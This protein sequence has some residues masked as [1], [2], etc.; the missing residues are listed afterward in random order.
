MIIPVLISIRSTAHR[1]EGAEDEA[2]TILTSGT[3]T[4]LSEQSAMIRYEET[5]DE[6]MPP[7]T[8][9]ITIEDGSATMHRNGDYATSMVFRKGCRY[10]GEYHTP[11]GNMELA[12]FCTRLNCQL[13]PD[14]GLM[15]LRYQLDLNG[16]FAAVHEMEL[17]MVKQG[18]E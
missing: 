14:G 11:F 2:I 13:G 12:V 17:T 5:L 1:D 3:L 18:D 6:S 15:R 9:E 8:V 7:Q 16:Q 10:E 4:L